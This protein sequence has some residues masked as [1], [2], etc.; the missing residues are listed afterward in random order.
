MDK[1]P[2]PVVAGLLC[3]CPNCG[4]GPL[5]TKRLSLRIREA[6]AVC[7]VDLKQVDTGDGPA[8]FVI[9]IGGSVAVFGMLITE[10]VYRPPI[11]VHFVVWMP[12]AVILCLGLLKPFKGVMAALQFHNHASEFRSGQ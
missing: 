11:W 8:V 12:L 6:C 2:N 4:K 7:N 3:R 9:L 5:F 10:A 1:A